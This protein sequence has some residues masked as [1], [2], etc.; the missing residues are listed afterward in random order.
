MREVVDLAS[1]LQASPS[2]PSAPLVNGLSAASASADT[3]RRHLRGSNLLLFGRLISLGVNLLVNVLL[4]RYL[5]KGEYG[6]FAYGLA[7]AAVGA[8]VLLLGMP[9]AVARFAPLYQERAEHGA[10]FGT[11]V[12][13]TALVTGLGA[14][15]LALAFAFGEP[16]AAGWV[17]DPLALQ[18]TFVLIVLAPLHALDSLFESM[19]V[20]FAGSR[21]LFFRRYLLGPLLRLAAVVSVM[22]CS[23]GPAALAWTYLGASLLCLALYWPLLKRAL[24][25]SGLDRQFD[26]S[27][28]SFRWR[29]LL[30]YGLP[31]V[32]SDVLFTARA[33]IVIVLLESLRDTSEVA[34]LNAF[35]K[36]AALNTIVLQSMRQLFLP[37]AA[38]MLARGEHAAIAE[39]YRQTA[40]WTS[41]L[42]FPIFLPCIAMPETVALWIN[43][44]G[45]VESSS[46]LVVLAIGEYVNAAMGLNSYTLNVYARMR[47]LVWTQMLAT[48]SAVALAWWL[49]PAYGALGAALGLSAAFV[50]QN[51]LHSW[52]LQRYTQVELLRGAGVYASLV[53]AVLLLLALQAWF[54]PPAWVGV[55]IVAALTLGLLRLH[56]ET[57]DLAAVLPEFGRL[58]LFGRW[59]FSRRD[60][61]VAEQRGSTP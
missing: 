13:S 42:T 40:I 14:L 4:V 38:R 28:L 5:S 47:F 51:A 25:R 10:M 45:Y 27:A 43:G 61:S 44:P 7:V 3:V 35:L 17:K 57:M 18:L 6:A 52:G 24:A 21:A 46:V 11:L 2:K 60:A 54:D 36:I 32:V 53:A 59:L 22:L 23:G 41:V 31:L 12:F 20:V 30:G 29:E 34:D 9:R 16:L 49:V 50:V 48:L 1:P 55:A 15:G 56:R 26:W 37:V 39:I 19:L 58:P 33:P 8:N